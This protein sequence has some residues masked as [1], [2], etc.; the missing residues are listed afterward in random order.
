MSAKSV[1]GIAA[2]ILVGGTLLASP[3]NAASA[4][5]SDHNIYSGHKNSAAIDADHNV[6]AGHK[7]GAGTPY[8]YKDAP[9]DHALGGGPG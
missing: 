5:S 2:A 9:G 7:A 3:V 6:Y 1:T 8:G 4:T